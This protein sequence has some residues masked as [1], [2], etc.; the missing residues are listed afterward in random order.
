MGQFE[1]TRWDR[2]AL[3]AYPG[4][5]R[6]RY[7]AEAAAMLDDLVADGRGPWRLALSLLAGALDARVSAA[8][9]PP[10]RSVWERRAAGAIAIATLPWMLLTPL[11]VALFMAHSGTLYAANG[12]VPSLGQAAQVAQAA[13]G[14]IGCAWLVSFAA[15]WWGWSAAAVQL[16]AEASRRRRRLLHLLPLAPGLATGAWLAL[17][18]VGDSFPPGRLPLLSTAL[19]I[20]GWVVGAIGWLATAAWIAATVPTLAMGPHAL[21]R[22]SRVAAV[23]GACFLVIAASVGVWGV[24]MGLQPPHVPPGM[25]V[26][27]Y[28]ALSSPFARWWVPICLASAIVAGMSL[29]AAREAHRSRRVAESLAG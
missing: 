2:V 14:A 20:L 15:V 10:R 1:P 19:V 13:S 17:V 25:A 8:G 24:A 22:G 21:R 27:S 3:R 16:H 26:V 11:V 7:S 18:L 6:D 23:V 9:M 4:W 12:P 5:W 28:Q 29:V